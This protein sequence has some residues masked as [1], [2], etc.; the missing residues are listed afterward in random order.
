MALKILWLSAGS[1]AHKN[2][3]SYHGG[4]WVA[5]LQQLVQNSN[6]V[7]LALAF[8]SNKEQPKFTENN[9]IYYPVYSPSPSGLKKIRYYYGGYKKI[10]NSKLID[11]VQNVIRDF[12]PDVIHLFG[13]EN[14]MASVLG[15]TTSPVVVHLQGLLSPTNNAFFPPEINKSSFLWPVTLREYVLRNNYIYAKNSINVRAAHEVEL[16]KNMKYCMGRTEWDEEVSQLMAPQS[17]YY[18][19]D[20]VLRQPFYDCAGKWKVSNG[21]LIITSTISNTVYKGLDLILKTSSLLKAAGVDF[22]WNIIGLDEH[23]KLVKFFERLLHTKSSEVNI[24]YLGIKSAEEITESLLHS[25]VYV[26]PS[27]IDNSPNSLCEAQLIGI[28]VIGTYVGGVPSLIENGVTGLLV[29]ANAPYELAYHLKVLANSPDICSMLSENAKKVSAKRHDKQNILK[30]L[31][32]TYN[33]ILATDE[34][35]HK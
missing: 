23:Q 3:D 15:K 18:H 11:N 20:E 28:P 21:K 8:I 31:L 16:Y 7:E 2:S 6:Q 25:S 1:G 26:H 4:G 29:P 32:S 9:T 30:Q 5:S 13:L 24:H 33:S 34:T 22:E 10:H 35:H 27:Y 17:T 12:Q 19:V 14:P